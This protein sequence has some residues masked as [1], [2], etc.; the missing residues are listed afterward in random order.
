MGPFFMKLDFMFYAD[1]MTLN[2]LFFLLGSENIW[3]H[4][5]VC[6]DLNVIS[7]IFLT[8]LCLMIM[9]NLGK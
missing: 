8:S 9:I 4:C 5:R 3:G 7:E 1:E 6:N 2:F